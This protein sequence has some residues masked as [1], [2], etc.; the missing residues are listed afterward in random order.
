MVRSKKALSLIAL[1][2][3][4][5]IALSACGGDTP[6]G[7]QEPESAVQ[8][9]QAAT[10]PKE[11]TAPP[12]ASASTEATAAP[13][14]APEATIPSTVPEEPTTEALPLLPDAL[15]G[16]WRRFGTS[17]K[18]DANGKNI[19]EFTVREDG[20]LTVNEITYMLEGNP[21]PE[22]DY[23]Y[24][25]GSD[26]HFSLDLSMSEYDGAT[27][28]GGLRVFYEGVNTIFEAIT[29]YKEGTEEYLQKKQI[30]ER[31]A[32]LAG[33]WYLY[34]DNSFGNVPRVT[35]STFDAYGICYR[36]E[37]DPINNAGPRPFTGNHWDDRIINGY[38]AVC[39]S[40]D[41]PDG[42]PYEAYCLLDDAPAPNCMGI[43]YNGE[44][45]FVYRKADPEEERLSAELSTENWKDYL[46]TYIEYIPEIRIDGW[47]DVTE[48]RMNMRVGSEVADTIWGME[49]EDG[50]IR[51]E[52][53]PVSWGLLRYDISSGEYEL[54]KLE[55]EELAAYRERLQTP[56]GYYFSDY[57]EEADRQLPAS[58]SP[59]FFIVMSAQLD[60]L[61]P[62]ETSGEES[63][64]VLEYLVIY[65]I[66]VNVTRIKG[67]VTYFKK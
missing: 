50:M 56:Y 13:S 44:E 14:S 60:P 3:A 47:G 67:T 65:E 5:V 7:T 8:T 6:S 17:E 42:V 9:T 51:F 35:T 43:L 2:L 31:K 54:T 41:G 61:N 37:L 62:A 66:E 45:L 20:T 58:D 28:K 40:S 34:Q 57:T 49:I 25:N 23:Y 11:S 36:L 16:T 29:F 63:G 38:S 24:F 1:L 59:C 4:A 27:I 12:A 46:K 39:Y 15:I 10:E 18:P 64:N 32:F 19:Q 48:I 30:A 21:G 55:E 22:S 52:Y 26:G 53:T 33:T